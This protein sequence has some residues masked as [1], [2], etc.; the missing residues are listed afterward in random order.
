MILTV[1]VKI[2][3]DTSEDQG[4]ARTEGWARGF[5]GSFVL[6]FHSGRSMGYGLLRR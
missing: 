4:L 6:A 1:G 3:L 2:F 5:L